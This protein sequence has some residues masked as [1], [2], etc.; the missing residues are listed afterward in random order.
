MTDH[1]DVVA[2]HR[3]ALER[4]RRVVNEV[5]GDRWEDPTPCSEWSVRD[6]TN[7][8]AAECLW[9]PEMLAGKTVQEVGDRFE[10]DVLGD[11]PA[12]AFAAASSNALRALRELDDLE[13]TVHL[14]FGDV[15]AEIYVWQL[16]TDALVHGWDIARGAQVPLQLDPELCGPALDANRPMIT[17]DVRKIGII[18]PE[19]EVDDDAPVC[20]RLL[21]FLGRDPSWTPPTG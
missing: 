16:F 2:M 14:S 9:V 7:H 6:V 13:Q 18:G 20:D 5:R 21:G 3:R 19:V 15:P 12:P 1:P 8:L 17:E 4:T 10:G 11:D